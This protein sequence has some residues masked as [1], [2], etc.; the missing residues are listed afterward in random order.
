MDQGVEDGRHQEV[1]D[2]STRITKA[3]SEC[4]GCADDVLVEE[5]GRPDL[6]W[7]ETTTQNTNEETE[8]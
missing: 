4:V 1:G 2:A 7:Y 8:G 3:G 6:A 5:A